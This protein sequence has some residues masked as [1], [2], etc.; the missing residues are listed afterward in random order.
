M[1]A[2]PEAQVAAEAVVGGEVAAAV[3]VGVVGRGEVRR[4]AEQL[5]QDRRERVDDRAGVLTGV[6]A[7]S[8]SV[9]SASVQ[10]VGQLAADDATVELGGE[11]GV[12]LAVGGEAARPSRRRSSRAALAE[13]RGGR[14]RRR[15][16]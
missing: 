16:R 15:G 12:R 1:L 10:P 7:F 14:G 8:S 9:G 5:G 2:D 4:A 11:V 6:A 3:D 13:R